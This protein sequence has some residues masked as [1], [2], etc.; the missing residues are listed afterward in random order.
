MDYSKSQL[1]KIGVV[2]ESLA[3][4]LPTE[5][6]D[7]DVKFS[8]KDA[9]DSVSVEFKPRNE[10]GKIWCDYCRKALKSGRIT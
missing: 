2:Y 3:R 9:A 4:L 7:Y 8:F 1:Y 5:G 6:R 10:L